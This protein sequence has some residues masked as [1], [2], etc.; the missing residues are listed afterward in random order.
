MKNLII[1]FSLILSF[2]LFSQNEDKIFICEQVSVYDGYENLQY[3]NDS[4]NVKIFLYDDSITLSSIKNKGTTYRFNN[5]IH[6]DEMTKEWTCLD[7]KNNGVICI[8]KQKKEYEDK[9]IFHIFLNDLTYR[10]LCTKV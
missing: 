8:V 5:I 1:I 7:Y 3:V 4:S 6:S 2:N 10:Y 9:F